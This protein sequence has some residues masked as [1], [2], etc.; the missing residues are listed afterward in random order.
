MP[1]SLKN[2]SATWWVKDS[3]LIAGGDKDTEYEVR[4]LT[5][6][7][8]REITKKHVRQATYRNPEKRDDEA[9]QDELFEYVLV[10]WRGVEVDG[11]PVPC[12]WEYMR[13]LDVPRRV[14]LLDVAGMNE[15]AAME[16]ARVTSFR[17]A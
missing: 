7:K 2:E 6:D 4:R 16:D 8:H 9:L 3:E 13:L 5:L 17:T 15:I 10:N 14:A 11:K 12:E 1:I